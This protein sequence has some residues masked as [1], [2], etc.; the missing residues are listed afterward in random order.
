MIH[1]CGWR[2]Y[3]AGEHRRVEIGVGNYHI[4]IALNKEGRI[5]KFKRKTQR[6]TNELVWLSIKRS[7]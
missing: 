3:C 1:F 7:K 2:G 4:T 6:Y 5:Q